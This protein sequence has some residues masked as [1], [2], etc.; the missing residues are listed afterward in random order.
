MLHDYDK[1]IKFCEAGLRANPL[2]FTL[3]NNI[4]FSHAAAGNFESASRFMEKASLRK[5]SKEEE[6][7]LL[8]TSGM[9]KIRRGQAEAGFADY[10]Q[11][12]ELANSE[13]LHML[14][15]LATVHYISELTLF[16]SFL[17]F[18]EILEVSNMMEDKR[19]IDEVHDI[20]LARLKPLLVKP[21]DE[22]AATNSIKLPQLLLP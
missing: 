12:I 14:A 18:Q 4:A 16:G 5:A 7:V 22:V 19:I 8:A 3:L 13:K 9:I 20:Y 11:A 17:S 15:Q 21:P 1:S 2:D 10:N 6:V